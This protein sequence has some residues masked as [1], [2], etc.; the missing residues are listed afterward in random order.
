MKVEAVNVDPKDGTTVLDSGQYLSPTKDST[1]PT[2]T[3]DG[4]YVDR[5]AEDIEDN[6]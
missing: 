6:V 1:Q 2:F 4:V 5:I 3:Y